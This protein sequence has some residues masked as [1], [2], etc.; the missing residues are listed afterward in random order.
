MVEAR[1]PTFV[2]QARRAQIIEVTV[3]VIA[4]FGVG[5]ASVARIAERADI[6]VGLV[7]YHFGSKDELLRQVAAHLSQRIETALTAATEHAESY[8]DA[9]RGLIES[10]VMFTGGDTVEAAALSQ[11]YR[12]G[13]DASS[14]RPSAEERRGWLTEFED[15]I[16]EGQEAGEF[17]ACDPHPVAVAML[18]AL[19]ASASEVRSR[20]NVKVDRYAVEIADLFIAALLPEARPG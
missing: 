10:H 12:S 9:V 4:E 18:A 13:A 20:P 2:E 6:S 11:I 16:R 7:S 3:A 1:G 19:E 5:G 14:V 8:T 17:R 15:M